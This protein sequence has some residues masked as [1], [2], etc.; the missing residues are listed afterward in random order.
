MS[1]YNV[2]AVYVQ[3]MDNILEKI[4]NGEYRVGDKIMSERQM[5]QRYGINRLTVR[6]AIKHLID[7]GYLISIHGKGT[8]VSAM[9][10]DERKVRFGD[11]ENVS[12]S[13]SL[14][15]SGYEA[16]RKVLSFKRMA[17]TEELKNEFE[18][19]EEVYELVR[20]STIDS[21]PYAIQICYFPAG[22]FL[23]PERF[24]FGN[25]SLYTYM[26]SQGHLPRKIISYME[27]TSLEEKYQ[28]IMG[29]TPNKLL[30]YYEYYGYDEDERLVEFTKAYYKSE[31][32]SF[33]YVT[34]K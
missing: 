15:Q 27:A 11:N 21:E 12:L 20:L 3:L 1:D 9:P 26:E 2:K 23:D 31:Y 18:N 6:N 13:Y 32:T 7:A 25:N 10:K 16:S 33:T 30:F 17:I 14:R 8:F 28:K 5:S 19:C 24:D 34:K 4:R 22:L 29:V